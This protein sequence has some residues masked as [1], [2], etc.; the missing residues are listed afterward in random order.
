MKCLKCGTN[1]TKETR[2]LWLVVEDGAFCPSCLLERPE[3]RCEHPYRVT[4]RK[5]RYCKA[6]GRKMES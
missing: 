6:C 5:V 1:L 2:G 3:E 4:H